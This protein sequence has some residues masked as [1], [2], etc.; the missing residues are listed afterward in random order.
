MGGNRIGTWV[1]STKI[2]GLKV[3]RLHTGSVE[4]DLVCTVDFRGTD[5]MI[6]AHLLRVGERGQST[7]AHTLFK[8][9]DPI[10]NLEVLSEGNVL[11]AGAG[12]RLIIGQRAS[13]S[14]S[15][16]KDLIYTWREVECPE[17]ITSLNARFI[18]DEITPLGS[19]LGTTMPL[20]SGALDIA[21]GGLQGSIFVYRNLLGELIQKE[22]K[23]RAA[24]PVSQ[25]LHWHRN[26]VGAIKWSADGMF[27]SY[28]M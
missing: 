21:T 6:T 19:R 9:S 5:W 18:N 8:S 1:I 17:W 20:T 24:P 7:E 15:S 25:K 26:G 23:K 16:L 12:R 14:T 27:P 2:A 3:T 10:M 11:V 22:R 28:R 13:K 4:E